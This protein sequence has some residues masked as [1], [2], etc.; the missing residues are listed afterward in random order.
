MALRCDRD[1]AAVEAARERIKDFT[2]RFEIRQGNF[3]KLAE[4]I[5]QR[6]CDGVLADLGVSSP[7]LDEPERG[8][9]FQQDGP[10]DMRMD[11]RN[12]LTAADLVNGLSE[13]ELTE[14]FR[15]LGEEPQARRFARAIVREREVH[16]FERTGQL[17]HL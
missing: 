15:D 10:L 1:P 16:R 4:W 12:A 11:S 9:S 6:S 3:S 8:F 2:G 14:V 13:S 17:A 7:Q 5:G